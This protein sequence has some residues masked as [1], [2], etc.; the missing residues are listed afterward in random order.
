[1]RRPV[2]ANDNK[3]DALLCVSLGDG[4]AAV[5]ICD[6]A[7]K[8]YAPPREAPDYVVK[9]LAMA[10]GVAGPQAQSVRPS[11]LRRVAIALGLWRG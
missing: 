10:L 5:V 1:M 3:P 4:T 2:P 6:D 8:R 7:R 11:V 9:R